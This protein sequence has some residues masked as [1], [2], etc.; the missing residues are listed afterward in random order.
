MGMR[1]MLNFELLIYNFEF[2]I[3]HIL[4]SKFSEGSEVPCW[5]IRL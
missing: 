3:L 2:C 5:I 4:H 1:L